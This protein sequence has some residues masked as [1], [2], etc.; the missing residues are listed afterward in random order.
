MIIY[1]SNRQFTLYFTLR[2]GVPSSR[3][4]LMKG[5]SENGFTFYTN[6]ESRKGQELVRRTQEVRIIIVDIWLIFNIK[7]SLYEALKNSWCYA[8]AIE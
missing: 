6:Y 1:C 3:M 8:L 4:V 5:F 2:N 7:P